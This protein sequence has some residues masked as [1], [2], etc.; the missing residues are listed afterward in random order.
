MPSAENAALYYEAGQSMVAMVA[1][2]DSGDHKIFNSAD[3]LWS[4]ES[5]YSPDIK[6][7]GVLTGLSVIPAA[8]GTNDLVDVLAGTLNLNGVVATINADTDVVCSRGLTTDVCRINSIV[9]TDAGVVDVVEGT[10]GTA[11]SET[12]GATGGPPLI[13]VGAVEIAQVRFTSI[14]SAAVLS[15]EIKAIPN[16][17]R[18]MALFPTYETEFARISSSIMGVAGI[19][20]NS[21]L[22]AN[23]TGGVTKAVYA[24]YYTPDFAQIPK[25]SDFKRAANS[26]SVSSTQYYGG[27]VGVVSSS[28][29]QGGFKTYLNDG[30]TDAI[31]QKEGK[32]IWFK[33]FPDRLK[34][35]YVLTQGYLGIVEQYPAGASIMADCTIGAGSEGSRVSS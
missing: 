10:D 23:H 8:S 20:F 11:I 13:P 16:S 18:E 29:G 34:L 7:N 31:L 33:F 26:M 4:D 6:P 19:T 5:G 2:T 28:L 24:Q 35:P 15:T 12:R 32:N 9:I 25:S 3:D 30:V 21:A 1:L 27:T 14:T 22:M 17:H